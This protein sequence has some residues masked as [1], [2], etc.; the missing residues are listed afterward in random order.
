MAVRVV[1]LGR[2]AGCQVAPL[3][4]AAARDTVITALMG[5]A[6]TLQMDRA[7]RVAAPEMGSGFLA[8]ALTDWL[9]SD[10][11]VAAAAAVPA[12]QA[13]QAVPAAVAL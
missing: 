13:R 10:I 12:D 11:V 8:A 2:E 3:A 5:R 6:A 9:L 7:A 4:S 1:C